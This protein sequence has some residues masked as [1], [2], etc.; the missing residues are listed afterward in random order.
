[1]SLLDSSVWIALFLTFD[2]NHTKAAKLIKTIPR[3][4]FVPYGV[5]AETATVLTYKHSKAQANRFL[6]Y[7]ASNSDIVL[8]NNDVNEELRF[9]KALNRPLSFTDVSLIYLSQKLGLSIVTFD[10]QLARILRN[11]Y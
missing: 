10:K 11:L 1:M 9:F 5:V 3:P 8:L 6:E 2:T 4:I 7:L